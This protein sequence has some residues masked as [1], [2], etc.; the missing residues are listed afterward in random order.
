MPGN[1]KRRRKKHRGTQ[2]GSIDR[3]S[4]SRPRNRDEARSRA[5]NQRGARPD[6]RDQVPTWRGATM[7]GL[8]FAALL[9]PISLLFGQAVPAAI[10]LTVI[11][12]VFYVPLGYYTD[13][14]FYRRRQSKLA[15][16]RQAKQAERGKGSGASKDG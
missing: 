6:R 2:T 7:R 3:R 14:F 9:F 12:A 10:I 15:A 13:L 4:R 11:A 16:A 8:F 5:R 1:T